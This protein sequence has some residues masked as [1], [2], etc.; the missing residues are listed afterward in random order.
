MKTFF[1]VSLIIVALCAIILVFYKRILKK[2]PL[3]T[4]FGGFWM[5][6]GGVLCFIGLIIM[7]L[8]KDYKTNYIELTN[9]QVLKSPHAIILDV[10]NCPQK[11]GLSID[12]NKL[13]KFDNHELVEIY[14][15]SIKFYIEETRS[16]YHLLMDRKIVWAN[17]E[18]KF[19]YNN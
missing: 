11:L 5:F 6:L 18:Y 10:T 7:P 2:H 15:D 17:P 4:F 16:F 3:E 14:N 12:Y 13:I 19:Y 8:C 1:I 9:Y